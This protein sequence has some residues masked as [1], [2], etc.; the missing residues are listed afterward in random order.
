VNLPDGNG[1]DL[2][3]EIRNTGHC[4]PVVIVCG[5]DSLEN[6]L[7]T[8]QLRAAGFLA[9]PFV[10]SDLHELLNDQLANSIANEGRARESM[11][12][13]SASVNNSIVVAPIAA[14]RT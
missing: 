6:R 9:K 7:R 2:L 3:E 14:S 8:S 1:L 5:H 12:A 11:D 13:S 10:V 4:P